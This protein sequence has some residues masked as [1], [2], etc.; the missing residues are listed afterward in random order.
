MP[1]RSRRSLCHHDNSTVRCHC[2][3]NGV[4]TGR[5]YETPIWPVRPRGRAEWSALC[6]LWLK[7]KNSPTFDAILWGCDAWSTGARPAVT[8]WPR[9]KSQNAK[10]CQEGPL[11]SL[12]SWLH[13]CFVE[14]TVLDLPA[15]WSNKHR[16]LKPFLGRC[17]TCSYKHLN[18]FRTLSTW[19]TKSVHIDS[20][21]TYWG[22]WNCTCTGPRN[23]KTC[24]G[25]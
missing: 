18:W 14:L 3:L 5:Q 23:R 7:K 21:Q 8:L 4:K 16:W 22:G 10:D 24:R 1:S 15:I 25:H 12:D 17:S 13:C 19:G 9:D 6:P 11:G 20:K 2:W